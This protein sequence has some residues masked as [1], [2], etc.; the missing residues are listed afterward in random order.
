[1]RPIRAAQDAFAFTRGI[2]SR[3]LGLRTNL[4]H[5]DDDPNHGRRLSVGVRCVVEE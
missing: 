5:W 4:G 1:M 3:P 2:I